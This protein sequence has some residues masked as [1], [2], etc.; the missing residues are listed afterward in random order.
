MYFI[1]KFGIWAFFCI[2]SITVIPKINRLFSKTL[3]QVY[4]IGAQS[5][6]LISL[7]SLFTG[8]VLGLQS[9]Y[10]MSM[11]GAQAML[12]SLLSLS[13]IRELAPT[14]TAIML[15]GRAGS[16]MTAEIGVMRIYDQ[17]D[18][19][20]VMDINPLGFLVTPRVLASFIVFPLLTAIFNCIG[21]FGG[22]LSACVL[23]PLNSGTY[24]AGIESSVR[25]NDIT[26]TFIKA[27]IF[28]LIV[29]FVSCYQGYTVH[30]RK[31]SKGPEAVGNAT[32]SAVVFSSIYVLVADYVLT[33]F[34]LI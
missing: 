24:L 12:G 14:L 15:A 20:E 11:F 2:D 5:L 34:L 1:Q 4:S 19:L 10:A 21:L 13:L 26:T 28:G 8:L 23:L 3:H 25:M 30:Q 31:E 33:T 6:F 29:T 32:T 27:V 22:Y 16:A 17:V 7:I 18:A 9:Y